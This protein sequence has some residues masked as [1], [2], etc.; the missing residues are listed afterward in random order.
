MT[1][2][3]SPRISYLPDSIV[4]ALVAPAGTTAVALHLSA[5]KTLRLR[6]SKTKLTADGLFAFRRGTDLTCVAIQAEKTTGQ[7]PSA[8][9]G[10]ALLALLCH[11]PISHVMVDVSALPGPKKGSRGPTPTRPKADRTPVHRL[12]VVFLY[13]KKDRKVGTCVNDLITSLRS[14]RILPNLYLQAF[15]VNPANPG[16]ATS[17][18]QAFVSTL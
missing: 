14:F 10:K 2:K 3:A 1:S 9:L 8:L 7:N 16:V 6:N 18:V 17:T 5:S 15:A 4:S 13:D 12:A 11:E